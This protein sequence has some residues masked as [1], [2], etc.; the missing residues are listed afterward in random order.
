MRSAYRIMAIGLAVCLAGCVERKMEITSEPAGATVIV[1]DVEKGVTPVTVDF[2]WYGDYDIILRK[3]GYET[4]K[5]HARIDPPWYELPV[6]D[7]FS[8]LAPWTYHDNCY[9]HYPLETYTPPSDDGLVDRAG[10]MKE[11]NAEPV[12]R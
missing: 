7:F 5:T 6:L 10:R 4:L 11:R 8:A 2:T 1:S 3:D 9:L 12:K